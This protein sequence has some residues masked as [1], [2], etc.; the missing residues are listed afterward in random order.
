VLLISLLRRKQRNWKSTK[1]EK[2]WN[3][4]SYCLSNLFSLLSLS[5]YLAQM[6]W[7][8]PLFL[9]SLYYYNIVCSAL[10]LTFKILFFLNNVSNYSRQCEGYDLVK[11]KKETETSKRFWNWTSYANGFWKSKRYK[12]FSRYSKHNNVLMY[13]TVV[14]ICRVI[15]ILLVLC[16]GFCFWD[17]W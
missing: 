2:K 11:E 9:I 12:R 13:P 1:K 6:G 17:Q 8:L 7:H 16:S 3:S 5:K 15:L 10:V 4:V 14:C